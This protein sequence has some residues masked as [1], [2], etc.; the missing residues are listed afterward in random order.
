MITIQD[1]A[2]AAGVS[3]GTVSY[4][5]SGKHRK[6]K[7]SDATCARIQRL[8]RDM[9]YRA[10]TLARDVS[11]GDSR[12]MGFLAGGGKSDF[13][14]AILDGMQSELDPRGY[15]LRL[16]HLPPQP[17][18]ADYE[19]LLDT[20]LGY[21][22][23]GLVCHSVSR[24]VLLRLQREFAAHDVPLGIVSNSYLPRGALHVGSNDAHGVAL[25]VEHLAGLG[26]RRIAC[27]TLSPGSPFA[28]ARQRGF[29]RG[30]AACGLT[31]RAMDWIEERGGATVACTRALALLRTEIAPTA[32]VCDGDTLALGLMS[33]LGH[34]RIQTPED[35][36]VVGF[37]NFGFGT[38]VVPTL[39]TVYEPFREM[40]QAMAQAMLSAATGV[41]AGD[42]AF[43]RRRILDTHLIVRDSTGRPRR[44]AE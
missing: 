38:H 32:L 4:V 19:R 34:E 15:S 14:Q 40:G 11:T 20:A 24:G 35:V 37:G 21:R 23:A 41:T 27:I 30:M 44:G 5:L 26:H 36:S 9:G 13:V 33:F 22:L 42:A 18:E 1:I 6:V 12:F 28:L 31:V 2:D 10:N 16:L 29:R 7:I 43:A 17:G 25:A 39:T 8:A 3:K